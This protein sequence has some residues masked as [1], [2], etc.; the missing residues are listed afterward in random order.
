MFSY[1]QRSNSLIFFAA[2]SL[3]DIQSLGKEVWMRLSE[4]LKLEV[5]LQKAVLNCSSF[6]E[7]SEV[8]EMHGIGH[9]VLI[10]S[11]IFFNSVIF[12]SNS[13]IGNVNKF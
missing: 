6:S 1:H 13:F 5:A 11:Q 9:Q 7:S 8:I 12:F 2:L 10:F 3:E 4:N